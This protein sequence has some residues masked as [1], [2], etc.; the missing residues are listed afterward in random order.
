VLS[1]STSISSVEVMSGPKSSWVSL[2]SLK[3]RIA[4]V[5]FSAAGAIDAFTSRGTV[6]SDYALRTSS[7]VWKLAQK[8]NV[9]IIYGSS[10]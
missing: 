9:D 6:L 2:P 10:G 3:Q 4:T 5:A 8:V 7:K 1:D